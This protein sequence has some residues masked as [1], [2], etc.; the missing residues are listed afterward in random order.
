[1]WG[2]VPRLPYRNCSRVDVLIMLRHRHGVELEACSR[3]RVEEFRLRCG[4]CAENRGVDRDGFAGP[5]ATQRGVQDLGIAKFAQ[6]SFNSGVL[7]AC[8][9]EQSGTLTIGC[10]DALK[11]TVSLNLSGPGTG[12]ATSS[13]VLS[14]DDG[15]FE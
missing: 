5:C 13:T 11:P 12:G 3:K 6:Q 9:G 15:S 4:T 7:T 8:G 10:N 14:V 2:R 1:M